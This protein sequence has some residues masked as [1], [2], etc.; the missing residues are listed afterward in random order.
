MRNKIND[1]INRNL[2]LKESFMG[3]EFI[4]F[5]GNNTRPYVFGL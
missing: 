1:N 4:Q 5:M 3:N 2:P